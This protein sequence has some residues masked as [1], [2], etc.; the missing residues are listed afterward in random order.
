MCVLGVAPL[1][2]EGDPLD[3]GRHEERAEDAQEDA[4]GIEGRRALA[5][6]VGRSLVSQ[7][8]PKSGVLE[9]RER[10]FGLPFSVVQCD[11]MRVLSTGEEKESARVAL[12]MGAA[13]T[14]FTELTG[15][16]AEFPP[17]LSAYLLGSEEAKGVFLRSHP[18]LASDAPMRMGRLEGSGVPG[19]ADW[20]WWTGGAEKR[21]DGMV[22][23]ALDWLVRTQGVTNESHAWLHEG[24]GLYL[25]HALV[26]TH[27]TWFVRPGNGSGANRAENTA[28]RAQMDEAGADWMALARGLFAPDRRFDF[29]ELLHLAAVELD[30]SDYLRMHALVGY[31]IEV[32]PGLLGGLVQRVGAGDDPRVV[33]EESLGVS[34][35]ELRARLDGWLDRREALIARAEG[36]RPVAELEAQW[37]T[38][39]GRQRRVA[40]AAFERGLAELDTAQMRWLRSVLADAPKTLARPEDPP[41]FD[42]KVH[43]PAQPIARKR[44]SGGDPRVKKL[45]KETRRDPDPRAPVLVHGY[46]WIRSRVVKDGDPSDL[47]T[48]FRNALR[49]VP[50]G[51]DLARSLVLA[52]FDQAI[53]DKEEERALQAAFEHAYTDR[54]GNVFPVTLF[55][56]WATGA[57]MEM[58][59]VDTLGIVH[60]VLGEWKRWVAPVP[61]NEQAPLYKTIGDLFKNA[62]RARELRTQLAD[63]FLFPFAPARPGYETQIQNLQALWASVDSDPHRLAPLLPDGQGRDAF[64]AALLDRCQK[65]YDYYSQGR[66]RASQLRRDGEEL[67]KVLGAALDQG[68]AEGARGGTPS[69]SGRE[70]DH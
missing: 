46:D 31:L 57:T 15:L 60:E 9:E 24:L 27:L 68:G 59:D 53:F 66:A 22:R 44:L 35:A 33:L 65:D 1:L 58:P 23:F 6:L 17:G 26:G 49:G 11:G 2:Q 37:N 32:H 39:N 48:Q 41:Y 42:P 38:L 62:Q 56:M 51:A 45:L 7:A 19:T 36:R 61:G 55:E 43:A 18:K 40:I 14:L 52:I 25:T 69:A 16:Q 8:P 70:S 3:T 54:E 30:T 34:L 64:L 10:V 5:A 29:E 63:L 13:R 12:A 47:E 50:P 67:R 20:V 4:R 21:Q 28:L